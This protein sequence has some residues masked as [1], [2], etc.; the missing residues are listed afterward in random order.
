MKR[1][2]S[3]LAFCP[4]F[5]ALSC[6]QA[7]AQELPD[8]STFPQQFSGLI[9][10]GRFE[11]ATKL[12]EETIEAYPDGWRIRTFRPRL[13]QGLLSR[14]NHDEAFKQAK[15]HVKDCRARLDEQNGVS[16]FATAAFNIKHTVPRGGDS[17]EATEF[18]DEVIAFLETKNPDTHPEYLHALAMASTAQA[19]LASESGDPT[20]ALA[21]LESTIGRL[22]QS[23]INHFAKTK[24]SDEIDNEVVKSLPAEGRMDY[25][26]SKTARQNVV[27]VQAWIMGITWSKIKEARTDDFQERMTEFADLALKIYPNQFQHDFVNLHLSITKQ[28]ISRDRGSK[29]LYIQRFRKR[30]KPFAGTRAGKYAEQQAKLLESSY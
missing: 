9:S 13:V 27:K 6:W 15:L 18:L 21:T 14:R 17:K 24:G 22:D 4:F 25:L 29:E 2:V 7:G 26:K 10:Q 1:L 23:N 16:T 20:T 19:L 28:L 5:Y 12:L 11:E 30:T 3:F 8:S